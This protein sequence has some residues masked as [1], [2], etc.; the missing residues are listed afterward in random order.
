MIRLDLWLTLTSGEKLRAAELVFG[1][2]DPQGRYASA[3]RY[4][5][6]YLADARAFPPGLA[7]PGWPNWDANGAWPA[8]RT[9]VARLPTRWPASPK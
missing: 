7:R 5:P 8:Q 3:L 1:N 9:S 4:T 6:E 2:T